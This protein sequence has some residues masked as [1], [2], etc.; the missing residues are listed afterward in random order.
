MDHPG[1]SDTR[2]EPYGP[3]V[4]NG[5]GLELLRTWQRLGDAT[6]T[7]GDTWQRV[8]IY[9]LKWL[10]KKQQNTLWDWQDLTNHLECLVSG[11][12]EISHRY[13][14]HGVF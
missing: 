9:R 13:S 6:E 4:L 10:R 2:G 1:S 8:S 3:L 12:N 11:V 7:R 5:S 14:T